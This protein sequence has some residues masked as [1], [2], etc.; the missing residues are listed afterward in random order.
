VADVNGQASRL[1]DLS[2]SRAPVKV[3]AQRHLLSQEECRMA[4]EDSTPNFV[5]QQLLQFC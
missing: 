1:L 4:D 2:W 3:F 5:V